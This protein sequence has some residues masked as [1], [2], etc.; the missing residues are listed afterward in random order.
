M[1]KHCSDVCKLRKCLDKESN[2]SA[3]MRTIVTTVLQQQY[4]QMELI[5]LITLVQTAAS[6][7]LYLQEC[8]GQSCSE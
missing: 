2:N 3:H 1:R 6:F 7:S 4:S 5:F 8:S